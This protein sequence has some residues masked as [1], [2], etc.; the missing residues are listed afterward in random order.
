MKSHSWWRWEGGGGILE[1]RKVFQMGHLV[2]LVA[3]SKPEA[4]VTVAVVRRVKTLAHTAAAAR[5]ILRRL[6][7]SKIARAAVRAELEEESQPRALLVMWQLGEKDARRGH[8]EDLGEDDLD[9]PCIV[10][11]TP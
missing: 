7:G 9:V 3:T 4:H 2:V 5:A 8:R 11:A 6:A 1:S 10:V